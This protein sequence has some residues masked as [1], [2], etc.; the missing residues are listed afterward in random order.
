[1]PISTNTSS[2]IEHLI[3]NNHYDINAVD[4]LLS[5][6]PQLRRLSITGEKA[7]ILI[8]ILFNDLH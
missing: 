8:L 7:E 5:Y 6:V 1:V 2:P 4:A 3:I